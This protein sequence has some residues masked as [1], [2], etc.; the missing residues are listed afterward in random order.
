MSSKS[1][2]KLQNQIE[3]LN[4]EKHIEVKGKVSRE[5][6]VRNGYFNLVNGYKNYFC[7]KIDGSRIYYDNVKID[8]FKS[9][10]NF[11]RN[12]RKIIFKYVTQ[13]EEEIGS[14]FGYFF[15]SD[16]VEKEKN[17]GD[18]SLYKFKDNQTGREMLSRIYG[19]ISKRSNEYLFHYENKHSY[20]PS[21]I[22]IKALTFGN[23]IKLIS[24]TDD[25]YKMKLC[26]LYEINYVEG[27]NTYRR[28]VS[29]LSLINALRNKIAHSERIIDFRGQSKKR[30]IITKYHRLLKYNDIKRE[31]LLDA[32]LYMK[33][34]I[35]GKEYRHLI[36][37]VG[38]ELD[39]L[40]KAVHNN[41]FI[42]ICHTIGLDTS[43]NYKISLS[44]LKGHSH[45]INYVNLI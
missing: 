42:K 19:D 34:L 29:M 26:D 28:I 44:E 7:R 45:V 39:T 8:Q 12:L 5:Y 36:N 33:M 21:W 4:H 17:W 37:E 15:E 38:N 27:K 43:K 40:K 13:I 30:R 16:L 25:K 10:M 2:L 23:V 1:F 20:L 35:P 41:A 11:D 18:M 31:S 3:K 32:I 22:M 14:I 9:V 24:Y 6:L